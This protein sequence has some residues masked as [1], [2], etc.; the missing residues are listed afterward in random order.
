VV[1]VAG[2]VAA[3]FVAYHGAKVGTSVIGNFAASTLGK[4]ALVR[5]TSRRSYLSPRE[6]WRRLAGTHQTHSTRGLAEIVLAPSEVRSRPSRAVLAVST[7][8]RAAH[9]LS[10]QN[11]FIRLC[12]RRE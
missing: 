11:S 7:Q 1:L 6:N 12:R 9:S 5:E 2:I 3:V 8:V 10:V 4:P